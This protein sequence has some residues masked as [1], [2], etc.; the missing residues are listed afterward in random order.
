MTENQTITRRALLQASPAIIAIAAA[1]VIARAAESP[2]PSPLADLIEA[3]RAAYE[4]YGD[5]LEAW[6]QLEQPFRDK[7]NP[8]VAISISSNGETLSGFYELKPSTEHFIRQQI[9]DTHKRLR[10]IHCG[11][12]ATSMVPD[13]VA[14]VG[15]EVDEA[16]KRTLANLDAIIAQQETDRANAGVFAADEE[17]DR[18]SRLERKALAALLAYKPS[19]P[20]E[21]EQKTDYI[22][23]HEDRYGAPVTDDEDMVSILIDLL[24][25]VA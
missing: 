10:E 7:G 2:A 19:S 18:T 20:E 15:R 16:E 24:N 5:A 6:D 17:V 1:P 3:H 14:A 4:A 25:E 11:R 23:Q 8:K 21:R 12:W 9:I 22:T 13:F